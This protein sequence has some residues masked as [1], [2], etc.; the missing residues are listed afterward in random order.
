M[1]SDEVY[2]LKYLAGIT[3]KNGNK[4]GETPEGSNISVIG[5]EKGKTQREQNIQPGTDEWFK[6]WFA[7]PHL[8]GG[9]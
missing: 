3:D 4:L 8:T 7:R 5:S 6:L 9:K 2:R 1:T